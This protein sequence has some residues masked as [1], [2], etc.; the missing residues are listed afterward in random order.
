MKGDSY[1]ASGSSTQP[2]SLPLSESSSPPVDCQKLKVQGNE[3]FQQ[4]KYNEAVE[5]YSRAI[6]HANSNESLA[7]FY[8]NRAAANEKLG[9]WNEV[10]TDCNEALLAD[11]KYCKALLRRAGAYQS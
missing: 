5:C 10:I 8:Q 1:D 11:P 9:R 7:I 4:R 3:Y 2:A 6:S